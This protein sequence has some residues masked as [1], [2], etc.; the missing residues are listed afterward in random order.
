[1]KDVNSQ[2]NAE[3]LYLIGFPNQW[4]LD[5][6]TTKIRLLWKWRGQWK[7][8]L[9]SL[10]SSR[11]IKHIIGG[12]KVFAH[13]ITI[14]VKHYRYFKPRNT[15]LHNNP[16]DLVSKRETST[17]PTLGPFLP[18]MFSHRAA[19]EKGKMLLLPRKFKRTLKSLRNF[20]HGYLED[21]IHNLEGWGHPS[22]LAVRTLFFF[23]HFIEPWTSDS[24]R[25][26]F[27]TF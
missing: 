12:T 20:F 14:S 17:L 21:N 1:M 11:S 15:K 6:W 16:V 18:K 26:K 4:E 3:L 13:S 22:K 8:G 23:R 19:S 27:K 24:K 2:K 25:Q 9:I 5:S 10:I 7:V